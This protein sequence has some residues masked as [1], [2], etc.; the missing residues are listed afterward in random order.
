M[1][2][3]R[4]DD[5]TQ[6]TEAKVAD[7][8]TLYTARQLQTAPSPMLNANAPGSV[9]VTTRR[10][11]S[12]VAILEALLGIR[13]LLGMLGA[14]PAVGFAPIVYGVTSPFIAPVAWMFGLPL[15]D[16]SHFELNALV[17][18]VVYAALAW[19]VSRL[20]RLAMDEVPD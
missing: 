1:D 12:L 16:T 5:R 11:Y 17:A 4:R 15:P 10:V 7:S 8:G 6:A 3:M 18:L 9:G 2:T 19:V 13:L 14:D 20:M